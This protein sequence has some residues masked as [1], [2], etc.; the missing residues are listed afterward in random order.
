MTK[1][2]KNYSNEFRENAVKLAAE[3]GTQEAAD[4]LGVCKASI[5]VWK[6][7][8]TFSGN[9]S[10]SDI[11]WEKEAKKLQKENSYLRKINDVLKKSTAIFSQ[12]DLPGSK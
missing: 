1:K 9:A 6:R 11:D 2:R 5:G 4:Q 7:N 3:V 10:S 12:N 8:Q